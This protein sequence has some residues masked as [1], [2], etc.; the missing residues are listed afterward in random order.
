MRP[1]LRQRDTFAYRIAAPVNQ[2]VVTRLND[3]FHQWWKDSGYTWDPYERGTASEDYERGPMGDWPT[4][5]EFLEERYPAAHRGLMMGQEIARPLLDGVGRDEEA[6]GRWDS[7]PQTQRNFNMLQVTHGDNVPP[8]ETGPEAQA[9]HGYD[10]REVAA[11]FLLLH[12]KTHPLRGYRAGEDQARLDEIAQA[13]NA[14]F[15]NADI[16]VLH[17]IAQKRTKMQRAAMP[18]EDAYDNAY[19]SQ[20]H[21]PRPV[22]VQGPWYHGTRE[23]LPDGTILVPSPDKSLWRYFDRPGKENR[24][25]WVWMDTDAHI[26]KQ[27]SKGGHVYEVEPLDEGPWEWNGGMLPAGYASPRARIIRKVH[28][29]VPQ[30]QADED[31]Q[32]GWKRIAMPAPAPKGLRFEYDPNF[33]HP[34]A[35]YL[36]RVQ[37]YV[38]DHP[39]GHLE[40]LKEGNPLSMVTDRKPGEVSFIYVHPNY[41]RQSIASE[42][43]DWAKENAAPDLHHS[44]RRTD[45]GDKWVGYEQQRVAA[46]ADD[47]IDRLRGEF[48]D[49]WNTDGTSPKKGQPLWTPVSSREAM[50]YWGNMERFLSARYPA[51]SRDSLYMGMEQVEPLLHQRDGQWGGVPRNADPYETGRKAV[52][53]HGYDPAEIAAGML[54]LHNDGRPGREQFQHV[55]RNLIL[56]IIRNRRKMQKEYDSKPRQLELPLDDTLDKAAAVLD[57]ASRLAMPA[58]DA[59]DG[60]WKNRKTSPPVVGPFYHSSDH[61]L[62]DGTILLPNQGESKFTDDYERRPG[63]KERTK[64]VWMELDPSGG[65]GEHTY[66]VE[67]MDEGPWPW[68]GDGRANGYTS[69]RARIIRKM[70]PEDQQELMDAFVDRM[71]EENRQRSQNRP[72]Q[73]R[74]YTRTAMPAPLPEGV[75][76]HY[77]PDDS[78][79]PAEHY[80]DFY[81]PAIE[82]RHHGNYVGHLSWT[83][84]SPEDG[85]RPVGEIN[86]IMVKPE[87]RRHSVATAMFDYVR[88]QHEPAIHHSGF[89]SADGRS[90]RDY[91]ES[92]H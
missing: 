15:D 67:P 42:M 85:G 21:V 5:E 6:L 78:T 58:E 45:L 51:A 46:V 12:N 41:R 17:D 35:D 50:G 62:P 8:Y 52:E 13:R 39:V 59:Y 92:R 80:D 14:E 19:K 91:E 40:W 71:H 29:Y 56:K 83:D 36:G 81:A 16:D 90:W 77:H 48:H 55:N 82:A 20:G 9:Q 3:E 54:Y 49:W 44:Q 64:W 88:Q 11:A 30:L 18:A 47:T 53:K 65:W 66:E 26:A 2:N 43:F 76:F 37:A 24:A 84:G 4:I 89:L 33:I 86:G 75:T 72:R 57:F 22:S 25:D 38:D 31:G 63:W 34:H 1:I 10:P 32:F 74:L 60:N 61:D 70:T 23:D 68:N 79:I 87:Y 28:T 27:F 73:V 69:P 7:N